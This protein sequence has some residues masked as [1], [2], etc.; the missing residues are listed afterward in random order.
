MED[1]KLY[2]CCFFGHRKITETDKLKSNLYSEIEKL[3]TS[4]ENHQNYRITH[5]VAPYCRA[6]GKTYKRAL[7]CCRCGNLLY[8]DDTD[9]FAKTKDTRI[10][11]GGLIGFGFNYGGMKRIE[12]K[13][14]FIFRKDENFYKSCNHFLRFFVCTHCMMSRLQ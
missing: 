13:H 8:N 12:L 14:V 6:C 4:F 9:V 3:I 10:K 7:R 11:N 1:I 5:I 2:T